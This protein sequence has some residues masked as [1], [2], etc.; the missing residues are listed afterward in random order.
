MYTDFFNLQGQPFLLTPDHRF[1]FDGEPHRKALAN[2]VGGLNKAEGFVVM[3]GE[4]GA[5]KT[6]LVNY[7]LSQI[8]EARLVAAKVVTT[9]LEPE[10][11]LRVIAA[12]FGIPRDGTDQASLLAKI[13][14]FLS[15][16]CKAKRRPLLVIDEVQNL[17]NASF[18]QLRVLADLRF[19]NRAGL[20]IFLVGQP[21]FRD[22]LNLD[23]L[24]PI[25]DR[26][27]ASHHIEPLDAEETRNYVEHRLQYVGWKN[28]P[29]FAEPVF[30]T[31]HETTHGLPRVINLLC[32]R[33][34]LFA[35]LEQQHRIESSVVNQVVAELREEGS[36]AA[37]EERRGSRPAVMPISPPPDLTAPPGELEA[38][39]ARV[40]TLKEE[41]E[42][43]EA[44]LKATLAEKHTHAEAP[45]EP[46]SPTRGDESRTQAIRQFP[47]DAKQP[48]SIDLRRL[49]TEGP[50]DR[51][52]RGVEPRPC[53]VERQAQA[54]IARFSERPLQDRL[55]LGDAAPGGAQDEAPRLHAEERP[56]GASRSTRT[57]RDRVSA[58]QK[59]GEPRTRQSFPRLAAG[60][61]LALLGVGAAALLPIF[62]IQDGQ[63]WNSM[64]GWA[65]RLIAEA[66]VAT[67]A[68]RNDETLRRT[69][70]LERSGEPAEAPPNETTSR[71]AGG[72]GPSLL[73]TRTTA[74][75]T[76]RTDASPSMAALP[77]E[78]VAD[79][80]TRSSPAEGEADPFARL[81]VRIQYRLKLIGLDPGPLDGEVGT[82][83][84]KAIT[85]YQQ[86][87]GLPLDGKPSLALL[88][89]I[90]RE[91]FA[92]RSK[93]AND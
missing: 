13:E 85:A 59:V 53:L 24:T 19:G 52:N 56:S 25:R 33:L 21:Q 86:K 27:V 92:R 68:E 76:N 31:I 39:L 46:Q 54:N 42:K 48:D 14:G 83:T 67:Q 77:S 49:S 7:L 81:V 88:E 9:Q 82:R 51:P 84:A 58:K 29:S 10:S 35:F 11:L 34:L 90:E 1:F 37:S 23:S 73:H 41:L 89:H 4:V 66:H 78:D 15:D 44:R 93:A 87:H 80:T 30:A 18:E 45:A 5:G 72:G 40:T 17:A 2:I 63:A 12:A 47:S 60:G 16:S 22:M 55:I 74:E 38:L 69:G 43:E 3:T 36:L 70:E 71:A 75:S 32:D 64:F 79:T 57:D 28:D 26:V 6:T 61:F 8:R 91:R 65:N 62:D 20:Q 50:S